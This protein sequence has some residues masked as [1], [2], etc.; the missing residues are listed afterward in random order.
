M[1]RI[2]NI[3]TKVAA[4]V[5]AA[6]LA[7]GCVFEKESPIGEGS[8]RDVMVLLDINTSDLTTKAVI[9]GG[10]ENPTEAELAIST[11][12]IYAYDSE[13]GVMIGYA[14]NDNAHDGSFHMVLQ[15]PSNASTVTAD[16]YVVANEGAMY[17]NNAVV[18][19]NKN[20]SKAD[21]ESL[22]YSSLV[23]TTTNIP[24]YGILENKVLDLTA[25]NQHSGNV[26]GHAPGFEL[27][28]SISIS[29]YR[30]LAKIGVYAAAYGGGSTSPQI[31]SITLNAAGRRNLSYLFPAADLMDRDLDNSSLQTDRVFD[32]EGDTDNLVNGG[33]AS[34]NISKEATDEVKQNPANYTEILAPFYLAEVPY[35]TNVWNSPATST[36]EDYN[37]KRPV[38]LTVEYNFG[39]GTETKSA[40][41]HMPAIQRNHFYKVLC[42]IN[43]EGQMVLNINVLDWVKGDE[44]V[45]TFDY[46]TST[47]P[48]PASSSFKQGA[49]GTWNYEQ[50]VNG[51]EA[52]M[53]YTYELD[54]NE[55]IVITDDG[56]FSVDFRMTYPQG[57]TW[58]PTL[59]GSAADF[60][61]RVYER[62]S[63]TPVTGQIEASEKW[64][65][66]KVVPLKPSAADGTLRKAS[67]M[68]V[69][70][71]SW[72]NELDFLMINGTNDH[73]LAWG[74]YQPVTGDV[75]EADINKIVVTQVEATT[76]SE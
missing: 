2:T 7:A 44:W 58:M 35:G 46:P 36:E 40:T 66:I 3:L 65:T 11:V 1:Q 6:V 27:T 31:T 54:E 41:V 28:E 75:H 60:E 68:V 13:T 4:A 10:N 48:V 74:E 45:L 20:M 26:G 22:V 69:Y 72:L 38:I 43:A 39:E 67:L 47:N 76:I 15:V 57:Q 70:T 37:I 32:L 18:Q 33:I 16:F 34:K 71:P 63:K 12:R 14:D 64:Y 29:L 52:T 42:L 62:D 49:D 17:Y 21:L 51:T 73:D 30:S 56:A 19:L 24:M 23:S 61:I 25:G 53:Y 9:E 50:H 5:L 8:K 55:N 59:E